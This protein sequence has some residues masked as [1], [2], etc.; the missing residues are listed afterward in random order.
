MHSSKCTNS[1]I[2]FE[3]KISRNK[4]ASQMTQFII[5]PVSNTYI[6][7]FAS[8][9]KRY[10]IRFLDE[11]ANAIHISTS[12][13]FN[14]DTASFSLRVFSENFIKATAF[15]CIKTENLV[16]GVSRLLYRVEI[17]MNSNYDSN[18]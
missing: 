11:L 18:P 12:T 2:I 15:G 1:R 17:S 13:Y 9:M 8:P 5:I 6:F 7:N 3:K 10:H 14:E 16:D 4:V